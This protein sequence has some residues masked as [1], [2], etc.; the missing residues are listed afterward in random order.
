MSQQRMISEADQKAREIIPQE[1]IK[2]FVEEGWE[3]Q[4]IY[5]KFLA[6]EIASVE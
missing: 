5:H 2:D 3:M 4:L 6:S 1:N